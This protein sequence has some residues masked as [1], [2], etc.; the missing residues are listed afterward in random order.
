MYRHLLSK[1]FKKRMQFLGVKKWCSANLTPYKN[2]FARKLVKSES[3]LVV[4][5]EHITFNVKW[6]EVRKWVRF[7]EQICIVKWVILFASFWRFWDFLVENMKF[8]KN[9]DDVH[10]NVRTNIKKLYA[11]N[12]IF[13]KRIPNM[14]FWII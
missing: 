4:L 14:R 2:I 13:K 9:P 7:F 3:L 1:S 6:V 11:Q 8:K 12:N 5:R 10:W